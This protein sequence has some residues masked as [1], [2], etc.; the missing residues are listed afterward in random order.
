MAMQRA[1]RF[2]VKNTF[3][4]VIDA[5]DGEEQP[6]SLPRSRTEPRRRPCHDEQPLLLPLCRT[7]PVARQGSLESTDCGSDQS[8][9]DSES[10]DAQT[11][12]DEGPRALPARTPFAAATPSPWPE[13]REQRELCFF[14]APVA[15]QA[16]PPAAPATPCAAPLPAQQPALAPH[17]APAGMSI[18][19]RDRCL[20]VSQEGGACRVQWSVEAK[21]LK[22]S[23]K[24]VVSP[25]LEVS[26]GQGAP[27]A[28]FKL[29][30]CP[31]GGD[32]FRKA[33]GV[34]QVQLKCCSGLSEGSWLLTAISISVGSGRKAQM[35]RGPFMHRFGSSYVFSAPREQAVWDFG[36]SVESAAL[37]VT[38]EIAPCA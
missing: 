1:I 15:A 17:G 14:P 12:I 33:G 20:A 11:G 19:A 35:P 27:P 7:E 9:D 34:G 22:G 38:V 21:K 5:G 10:N 2:C 29:M 24:Q 8:T 36:A 23:E 37:A 26:L 16:P 31:S 30:L 32:S 13:S 18:S 25:P 6:P 4:D 28:T 3:I